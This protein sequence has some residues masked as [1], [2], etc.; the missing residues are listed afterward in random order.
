MVPAV[1][2]QDHAASLARRDTLEL[3][4]S[5]CGRNVRGW[6]E[7]FLKKWLG[8]RHVARTVI[9]YGTT[10]VVVLT[11]L[12]EAIA[13]EKAEE[14]K[15]GELRDQSRIRLGICAMALAVCEQDHVASL[16]RGGTPDTCAFSFWQ[17]STG[18]VRGLSP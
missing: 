5:E 1:V 16:A 13:H 6:F 4:A 3:L 14:A 2:E 15:E 7:A 11:K 8:N 12:V 17:T 18:M 10:D 9:R